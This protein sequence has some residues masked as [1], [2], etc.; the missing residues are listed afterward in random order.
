MPLILSI[1]TAFE[2]ASVLLS[3]G[4]K[5]IEEIQHSNQKDHASFLEP[6]IQSL[7]EHAGIQMHELDAV[8]VV[9]GPGSYTGL[10]VGLS[11]AKALCYAFNKPLLLLNT[12]DVMAL[13]LKFQLKSTA[14]N[15]LFCPMIDA[16]RMEVFTALYNFNLTILE[17]YSSALIDENF[18][19]SYAESNH[20]IAVG[21]SGA[22]KLQKIAAGKN[23]IYINP[24]NI[25][26]PIIDSGIKLFKGKIFAD[27]V[28]SEPY[29]IKPVHFNK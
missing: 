11:S 6:A 23:F 9:N 26:Q 12:L 1:N 28:Y 5:I 14:T 15:V 24:L 19:N 25:T 8:A 27:V 18:L 17:N 29:Y 10:R 13:A 2:T 22:P 16:R 3:S 20:L 21:G 7:F 4:E